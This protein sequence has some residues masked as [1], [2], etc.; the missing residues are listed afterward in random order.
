MA[1]RYRRADKINALNLIDSLDGDRTA[2]S[3]QLNIPAKTLQKWTAAEDELRANFSDYQKRHFDRL[4]PELHLTMLERAVA[5]VKHL[6]DAKLAEASASQLAYTLNILANHIVRLQEIA[7]AASPEPETPQPAKMELPPRPSYADEIHPALSK[8]YTNLPT[9]APATTPYADEIAP[10]P[11]TPYADDLAPL[12]ATPDAD[13][14]NSA[15]SKRYTNFPSRAPAT[16]P[17]ADDIAPLP[18]TSHENEFDPAPAPP[19]ADDIAPLAATIQDNESDSLQASRLR[20]APVPNATALGSPTPASQ[21]PLLAARAKRRRKKRTG[22]TPR[23]K[24][25]KTKHRQR[26]RKRR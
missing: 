2:A 11:T 16:T 9:P 20:T 17:Y 18:A 15:L 24:R 26:K 12:P 3:A 6:N 4:L 25:P 22:I 21:L 10:L 23:K 19:R 7:N 13:E 1:T 8:R 5:V 14:I